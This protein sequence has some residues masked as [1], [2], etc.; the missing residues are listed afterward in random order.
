[1]RS[2]RNDSVFLLLGLAALVLVTANFF[3]G[4]LFADTAERYEDLEWFAD[5][6]DKI[7][8]EYVQELSTDNLVEGAIA[9]M[10]LKLDRHSSFLSLEPFKKLEEET[11]GE[12]VG[13]GIRIFMD[14]NTGYVT[15]DTTFPGSPAFREGIMPG[16]MIMKVDGDLIRMQDV[17]AIEETL[18]AAKDA[19]R[20][21]RG[22]T[23]DLVLLRKEEESGRGRQIEKTVLRDKIDMQSVLDAKLAAPGIGYVRIADFN[24]H[25]IR[26]LKKEI[27][28]MVGKNIHG[29]VLDLRWNPGGLLSSA[30]DVSDLFLDRGQL[31]VSTKGRADNQN[32]EWIAKTKDQY[33]DVDVVV[34]MNGLSASA[35][36]IVAGALHDTDRA[37]LIGTKSHG[38]GSVQTVIPLKNQTALRLTTAHYYTPNGT[39]IEENEGIEPDIEVPP[40]S[41]EDQMRLFGQISLEQNGAQAKQMA[42]Q[43]AEEHTYE[44]AFVKWLGKEDDLQQVVE[45]IYE[46]DTTIESL[47]EWLTAESEKKFGSYNVE[48]VQLPRAVEWLN[49]RQRTGNSETAAASIAAVS[50]DRQ[51]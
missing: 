29:L 18:N 33:P 13:I 46:P 49:E 47:Q 16:D 23:V 42:R 31:I 35:S 6:F 51:I 2:N 28:L 14:K 39:P 4:L 26:D 8:T 15:V 7:D 30:V 9:G 34:L 19:I 24:E 37:V 12:Y 1:M 41:L 38:K 11:S 25:T 27:D 10:T 40:L 3:Q 22:T 43:R 36:E 50:A 17:S 21:P 48:D 32:N 44:K 45:K 5:A 20:G